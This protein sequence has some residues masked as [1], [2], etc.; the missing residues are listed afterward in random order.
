MTNIG[1][2]SIH[3]V[4]IFSAAG[5]EEYMRAESVRE[6]ER[7][8]ALILRQQ[9]RRDAQFRDFRCALREAVDGMLTA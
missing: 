5:F 6:G 4:F 1:S 7:N 8:T 9:G 2:E 3:F